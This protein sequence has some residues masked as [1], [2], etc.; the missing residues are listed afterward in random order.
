MWASG[1]NNAFHLVYHNFVLFC[2]T[3]RRLKDR[4]L[5]TQIPQVHLHKHLSLS[6]PFAGFQL[7]RRAKRPWTLQR[8]SIQK[9]VSPVLTP[10]VKIMRNIM[11]EISGDKFTSHYH[12]FFL[13]FFLVAAIMQSWQPLC[14]NVVLCSLIEGRLLNQFGVIV[15]LLW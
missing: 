10:P 4:D 6:L 5:K 13:F 2:L 1:Y 8:C 9:M 7:K 3:L 12:H 14:L 11:I 15:P